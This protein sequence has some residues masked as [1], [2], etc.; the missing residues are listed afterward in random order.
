MRK[1]L[2][3]RKLE[4]EIDAKQRRLAELREADP[5]RQ[6]VVDQLANLRALEARSRSIAPEELRL[7][8]A[9]PSQAPAFLRDP[10]W[11]FA[12]QTSTTKGVDLSMPGV[13]RSKL[14]RASVGDSPASKLG[15]V[16]QVGKPWTQ[17]TI[18]TSSHAGTVKLDRAHPDR[19]TVDGRVYV[20]EDGARLH[21]RDGQRAER[22][23]V[24]ATEP[25]ETY[26]LVELTTPDGA[27]HERVE[28]RSR[29]RGWVQAGEHTTRRSA[30]TEQAARDQLTHELDAEKQLA[31]D[32]AQPQRSDRLVD[33]MRLQHQNA[34]GQG[35]DDVIVEF[36]GDPPKARIRIIEVK[37][38]PHRNV[39]LVEMSAIR[40]SLKA[41]MARLRQEIRIA[42]GANTPAARPAAY[43][44]LARQ[45]IKALE[46]AALDNNFR[47][48]L[49]L[50]ETTL[51]GPEA[52][53]SSLLGRLRA[54]LRAS[55]E[56]GGRDVLELGEPKRVETGGPGTS[57]LHSGNG[58]K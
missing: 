20:I 55:P 39:S 22:G 41:N 53:N 37:D 33:W 46:K 57:S 58:E 29:K 34:Q 21:V 56:F 5:Q 10:A 48:E 1:Q 19:V 47:I 38:Y 54:E 8:Q 6:V 35:F 50:G 28:Y 51:I 27:V 24:L 12:K 3:E 44:H 17:T 52:R 43:R 40:E 23:T 14:K 42:V 31:H 16:V 18:V 9:D 30:A 4:V 15:K 11:L 26:R 25:P 49:R 36:R 2:F 7:M 32:P 45:Q 13:D